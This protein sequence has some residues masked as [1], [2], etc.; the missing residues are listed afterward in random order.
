[1]VDGIGAFEKIIVVIT[2]LPLLDL[3]MYF[4][5][6]QAAPHRPDKVLG[7]DCNRHLPVWRR[8]CV[9]PHAWLVEAK[10]LAAPTSLYRPSLSESNLLCVW[11][12]RAQASFGSTAFLA[13]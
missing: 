12:T 7:R 5:I 13:G 11:H 10:G 9:A 1:V 4:L 8:E 3:G 2:E 6:S